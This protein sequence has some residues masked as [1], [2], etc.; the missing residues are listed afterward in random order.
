MFLGYN[1]VKTL[2][3]VVVSSLNWSRLTVLVNPCMQSLKA[4]KRLL[5]INVN[6]KYFVSC[7]QAT[8]FSQLEIGWLI[9]DSVCSD[10]SEKR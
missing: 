9:S 10:I 5:E 6:T 1:F 3:S 4:L 7:R 2:K 8:H